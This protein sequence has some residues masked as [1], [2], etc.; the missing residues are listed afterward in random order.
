MEQDTILN[1][2]IFIISCIMIIG[3][4]RNYNRFGGWHEVSS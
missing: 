1:A 2:M 4:M 3:S